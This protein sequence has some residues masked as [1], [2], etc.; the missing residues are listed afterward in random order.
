MRKNL[1]LIH[2]FFSIT[3]QGGVYESKVIWDQPE[4]KVCFLSKVDQAN[5]SKLAIPP[6]AEKEFVPA[7]FTKSEQLRIREVVNLNYTA[8]E[9]GVHF[10]GWGTC[11]PSSNADV[12][13]FKAGGFARR[14]W[15]KMKPFFEGLSAIG[16]SG[17]L[18]GDGFERDPLK[19]SFVSISTVNSQ[20]IVHE[21]G[22]LSGLRHEQAH[23]EFSNFEKSKNPRKYLK[24]KTYME[25][26]LGTTAVVYTHYDRQSVMNS[27][28]RR[29]LHP[30][31]DCPKDLCLSS[32]DKAT[33]KHLYPP[34]KP[35]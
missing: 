3:A 23:P 6:G 5:L 25:E 11:E 18:L 16:Q 29:T 28:V 14:F 30:I 32:D 27:Y 19:K 31:K 10:V 35:K 2:L 20:T 1:I 13:L 7:V 15:F 17:L 34:R 24:F 8:D 21:F 22:H 12:F 33:L 4:I 26:D 9:T